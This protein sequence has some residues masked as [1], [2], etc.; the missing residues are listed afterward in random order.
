MGADADADAMVT[1]PAVASYHAIELGSTKSSHRPEIDDV[2]APPA[3]EEEGAKAQ[4]KKYEGDK[5]LVGFMPSHLQVRRT[6]KEA[7]PKKKVVAAA[8]SIHVPERDAKASAKQDVKA[9]AG[10]AYEDFMKEIS[11]LK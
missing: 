5:A 2:I 8:T 11:A 6:N 3:D 10:E 4:L 9:S 7:K 1:Y